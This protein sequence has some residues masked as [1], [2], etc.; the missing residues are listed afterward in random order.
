MGKNEFF[1]FSALLSFSPNIEAYRTGCN[2][3]N[4]FPKHAEK[5]IWG[6]LTPISIPTN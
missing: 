2:G 1:H 5:V 6:S 3:K 4:G